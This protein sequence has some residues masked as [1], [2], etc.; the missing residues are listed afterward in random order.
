MFIRTYAVSVSSFG[1]QGRQL[2]SSLFYHILFLPG[3]GMAAAK[4][5][6]S[7]PRRE[8]MGAA[9]GF[10]IAAAPNAFS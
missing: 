2:K 9:A 4:T 1:C 3:S 7:L 6:A 10:A 8:K 5:A